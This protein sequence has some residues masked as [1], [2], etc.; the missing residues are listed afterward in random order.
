MQMNNSIRLIWLFFVLI[1]SLTFA[2][3][4]VPLTCHIYN[5]S[6]SPIRITKYI[7]G[8]EVA[9]YYLEKNERAILEKWETGKYK[10]ETDRITCIID[11]NAAYIPNVDYVEFK[12]FGFWGRRHAYLQLE[13]DDLIYL[14]KP[15]EEYP[16]KNFSNQPE[17]FPIKLMEGERS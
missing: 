9:Q 3:C 12:G 2:G 6:E 13:K 15:N 14:L 8:K 11:P 5:N 16:V 1:A 17:G 10:I 7:S 4:T